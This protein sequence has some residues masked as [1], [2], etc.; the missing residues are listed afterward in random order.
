MPAIQNLRDFVHNNESLNFRKKNLNFL[1]NT[2]S[3]ILDLS[4]D[5]NYFLSD[6]FLE[7][8]PT[9]D[10]LNIISVNIRSLTSKIDELKH[11]LSLA[12]D[13]SKTIKII[14]LQESWQINDSNAFSL[15]ING[16]DFFYTSRLDGRGG[17]V[18]IYIHTSL[19]ATLIQNATIQKDK[20]FEATAVKFKH[21]NETFS[22][23]NFYFSNSLP[24]SAS[25]GN[26]FN[27]FIDYLEDW[28][29]TI[30]LPN[31]HSVVT[32]D[33]NVNFLHLE[34]SHKAKTLF[35]TLTAHGLDLNFFLPTRFS[36]SN[37]GSLID[38]VATSNSLNTN[39][40]LQGFRLF[41]DHNVL[42]FHI[43]TCNSHT[44]SSSKTLKR[45]FSK[46][47][48]CLLK[49]KI[50]LVDW[51]PLLQISNVDQ[52]V[53]CFEK[54]FFSI[55]DEVAPL[56]EIKVHAEKCSFFDS[57]L[58]ELKRK[59]EHAELVFL[60]SNHPF[61]ANILKKAKSKYNNYKKLAKKKFFTENYNQL[62]N[63]PKKLW[64]FINKNVGLGKKVNNGFEYKVDIN[65]KISNIPSEIA[66]EFTTFL[67]EVPYKVESSVPPL[68]RIII[69][70][71]MPV[72]QR[73]LDTLQCIRLK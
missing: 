25:A 18:A 46:R 60:K 9:N 58:I 52:S 45:M 3:P 13:R 30:R 44:K 62:K 72:L 49:E 73:A 56:K 67:R 66:S 48:I 37:H 21:N 31:A 17:G 28:L 2:S 35:E 68:L 70:S 22:V 34:H 24:N 50:A 20:I 40:F 69:H 63:S 42:G 4:S 7:E 23:G 64:G 65:G 55:L 33:A 61:D 15:Q 54:I 12:A 1:E 59:I 6:E 71:V 29:N 16:Y 51:E 5:E 36:A 47:Q 8:L 27:N 19:N 38:N 53:D 32:F 41:S 14:C 43:S 57:N 26:S 39:T 11:F 10:G